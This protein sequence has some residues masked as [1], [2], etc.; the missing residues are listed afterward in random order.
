MCV[1]K[2]GPTRQLTL[3]MNPQL[4]DKRSVKRSLE[5]GRQT[6]DNCGMIPP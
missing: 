1:E 2:D 4:S 5:W 6:C 3:P